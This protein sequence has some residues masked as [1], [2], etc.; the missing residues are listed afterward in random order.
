MVATEKKR[1]S[2]SGKKQFLCAAA[3]LRVNDDAIS[4]PLKTEL[5]SII[6]RC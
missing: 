2:E 5:A 4:Q 3:N 6:L 1:E